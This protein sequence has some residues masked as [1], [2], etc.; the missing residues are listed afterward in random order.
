MRASISFLRG[1]LG[2]EQAHALRRVQEAVVLD[3]PTAQEGGRRD[4]SSVLALS[5][6]AWQWVHTLSR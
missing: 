4:A 6:S 1:A 5:R 3:R 2:V